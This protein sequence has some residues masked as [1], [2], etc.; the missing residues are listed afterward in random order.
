VPPLLAFNIARSV[1]ADL[2]RADQHPAPGAILSFLPTLSTGMSPALK[3][4]TTR[5]L[6]TLHRRLASAE[7]LPLWA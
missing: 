1:L 3:E 7:Q 6:K 2:R 5:V 4:A